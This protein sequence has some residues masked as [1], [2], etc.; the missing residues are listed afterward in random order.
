MQSS[1]AVN[2]GTRTFV[3]RQTD[4]LQTLNEIGRVMS[5]TLD[6]QTLYE[7]IY[8]QIG[9]VMDASQF[10]LALQREEDGSIEVP[11]LREDG[12]LLLDQVMPPGPS[13]TGTIIRTGTPILFHTTQEYDERLRAFGLS[14]GIVGQQDS[15]SGI[16]VPL[17][18]GSRTIGALTVQS[19]RMHA[20]TE[21]DM[22]MLSVLGFPGGGRHRECRLV[23]AKPAQC[24]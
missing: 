10:F 2:L 17:H 22:R 21:D 12:T 7:T 16:F 3:Q 6:L 11:Y 13:M 5:S 15:E 4:R 9:R 1:T 14:A 18:T 8:Q 24:A 19:P 23:R 20:Y